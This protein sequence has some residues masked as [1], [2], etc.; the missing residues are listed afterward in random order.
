[1]TR[2]FSESFAGLDDAVGVAGTYQPARWADSP[3]LSMV[4]AV[5]GAALGLQLSGTYFVAVR[6]RVDGAAG[7]TGV[8]SVLTLGD[9]RQLYLWDPG[10][11]GPGSTRTVRASASFFYEGLQ[12]KLLSF[13]WTT[14]GGTG[15]MVGADSSFDVAFL[16]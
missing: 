8:R 15:S 13:D 16:G 6:L 14:D 9:G 5:N 3:A 7:V 11:L 10:A 12:P 2:P 1:M 4:T